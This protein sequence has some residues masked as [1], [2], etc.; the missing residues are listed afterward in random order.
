MKY[1]VGGQMQALRRLVAVRVTP[2]R[3][4]LLAFSGGLDSTV[5]LDILAALRNGDYALDS[6]ITPALR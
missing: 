2:Y 5:L 4:L 3:A 6:V 1:D